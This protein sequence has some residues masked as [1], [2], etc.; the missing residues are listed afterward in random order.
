MK[1][2]S[3]TS[4]V[5]KHPTVQ[6][7]PQNP[8]EQSV[9]EDLNKQSQKLSSTSQRAPQSG[10]GLNLI[11]KLIAVEP[12]KQFTEDSK[13][14]GSSSS[15]SPQSGVFQSGRTEPTKQC[16]EQ[17]QKPDDPPLA[18]PPKDVKRR[19]SSSSISALSDIIQD[20]KTSPRDGNISAENI[21]TKGTVV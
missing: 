3:E 20:I 2:A 19:G 11:S 6:Q 10:E 4:T 15:V 17:K 5:S 13:R 16:I 1:Q 8:A 7:I 12:A 18:R 14:K 21:P 9:A